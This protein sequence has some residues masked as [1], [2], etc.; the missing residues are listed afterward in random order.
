MLRAPIFRRPLLRVIDFMRGE[1]AGGIVLMGAAALALI[2]A[3]SPLSDAYFHA[4][5]L[6][7]LGMSLLHWINDG[8]MA[9]FFLLVGLEIKREM[10]VGQLSS[11]RQRALP[12]IGALGGM[13]V[14]GLIFLAFNHDDAQALR[15]WAIPTATDIAFALGVLS[16]LGRRVPVSI[17]VFL[18]A[19]AI[20]DD[21]GAVVIIALFY[22]SELSWTWLSAAIGI[23][24]LLAVLN[25]TGVRHLAAY[26]VPGALLWYCVL[27]SG[28][29][30]TL[31]GVAL[32]LCI[33]A[34]H[35]DDRQH[36]PLVVLEHA[37][38]R[39][40]PFL[41]I[42]LFGFANAGLSFVGMTMADLTRPLTLGVAL[43]LLVGKLLGVFG[44]A[45][46]AIGTGI[47]RLPQG[48]SWMQ[49]VGVSLMCGIGFTMS[50]FISLLAYADQPMLQADAKIGILAGSM[51]A[52]LAGFII[53][54]WAAPAESL[55]M[56]DPSTVDR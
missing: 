49:L 51:L 5:H 39:V 32:A 47:A 33:P 53:L 10:L 6:Q 15:G 36:P 38:H 27:Q 17:K 24:A 26:L 9:V 55:S 23:L 37:L 14:P 22:T 50:L 43:G 45:S 29:H 48:A 42:P 28:V 12:G 21:L 54:R 46:L 41:I 8:L 4:Q 56:A 52:G 19:L 35:D 1:A 20:I 2:V 18:T 30:A 44:C 40:V 34:G 13:L 16:L 7:W 31:A 25:R 3:N 11:W